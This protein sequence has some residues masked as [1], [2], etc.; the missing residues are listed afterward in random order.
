MN[1][2]PLTLLSLQQLVESEKN[3]HN[4]L[5]VLDC[6][7]DW[8]GPCKRIAPEVERIPSLYEGRVIVL[9]TNIDE[10]DD[11]AE[12][13]AIQSLPTFLFFKYG[14]VVNRIEGANL[15]ILHDTIRMYVS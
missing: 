2:V 7:A 10:S 12:S 1:K 5:I 11:I 13:F 14:T 8:C 6:Y 4:R 15:D 3:A 9:K